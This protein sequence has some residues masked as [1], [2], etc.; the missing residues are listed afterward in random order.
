MLDN[1]LEEVLGV[2]QGDVLMERM[3]ARFDRLEQ[4][5]DDLFARQTAEII[6]AFRG[7]LIAAATLQVRQTIFAVIGVLLAVA[8]LMAVVLGL[9]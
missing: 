3:D 4:Q 9:G 7:E 5:F 2:G 6:A 8:V 1:R